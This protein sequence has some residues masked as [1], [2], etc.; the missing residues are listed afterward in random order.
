MPVSDGIYPPDGTR[1]E[2]VIEDLFG[3][4]PAPP[5]RAVLKSAAADGGNLVPM[6]F[7]MPDERK[8]LQGLRLCRGPRFEY[9][10]PRLAR[11]P[12]SANVSLGSATI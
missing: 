2:A 8:P 7:E 1:Q 5:E 11:R 10:P 6:A 4:S 3:M 9:G 12:G